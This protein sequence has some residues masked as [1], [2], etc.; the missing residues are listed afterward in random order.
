[1]YKGKI[2]KIIIESLYEVELDMELGYST[3]SIVDFDFL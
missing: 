3:S 2:Q 1:M